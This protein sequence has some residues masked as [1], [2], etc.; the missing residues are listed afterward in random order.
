M[1]HF[2]HAWNWQ[3]GD[4]KNTRVPS[5]VPVT[6]DVGFSVDY[7]SSVANYPI[8]VENK[9]PEGFEWLRHFEV[10]LPFTASITVHFPDNGR[11]VVMNCAS[12][13]DR[14][15]LQQVLSNL[16]RNAVDSMKEAGDRPRQIKVTS[17]HTAFGEIL[18]SVVDNGS[19]LGSADALRLFEPLY[20]TKEG[21]M[22]IGL[23]ICRT[24]IEGHRGRLWVEPSIPH[25]TAFRF[26]IPKESG[27]NAPDPSGRQP[28]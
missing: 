22:G 28:S 10:H 14:V 5:Y 3:H 13:G 16:L 6:S 23:S 15:Q 21:G 19:G 20:T 18:I 2:G 9:A 24:I 11:V 26:T 7:R 17:D 27:D 8:G 4:P 12:P 25:G 1:L